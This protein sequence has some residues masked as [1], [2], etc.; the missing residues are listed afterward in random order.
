MF[1]GQADDKYVTSRQ[2]RDE[3]GGVSDMTLWRWE[4]DPELGFPKPIRI[5]RR[6]YWR[7]AEI[8]AFMAHQAAGQ[9]G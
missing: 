8:S 4:N 7:A 6:R 9:Q 1:S 3:L 2:V 5:N